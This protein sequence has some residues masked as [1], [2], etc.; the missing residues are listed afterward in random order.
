VLGWVKANSEE[1]PVTFPTPEE[2]DEM[3][4]KHG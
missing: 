4:R 2:H 1:E 3:V